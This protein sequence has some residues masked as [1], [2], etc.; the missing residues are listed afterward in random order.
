MDVTE[1]DPKPVVCPVC[2]AKSPPK[3]LFCSSCGAY[4]KGGEEDAW[5]DLP[6]RQPP[7]KQPGAS[8]AGA[9]PSAPGRLA[10]DMMDLRWD[11]ADP[12]LDPHT[13]EAPRNRRRAVSEP[14]SERRPPRKRH[15]WVLAFFLAVILV[16]AVGLTAAVA[17]RALFAP[18]DNPAA[19][20]GSVTT[21]TTGTDQGGSTTTQTT[22]PSQTTTSTSATQPGSL[23]TAT[24][25]TA[26]STL[27]PE[28]ENSYGASNVSDG[29][30]STCWSEGVGGQGVGETIRVDLDEAATL[31][32]IEIANGYQKDQRRF[33]GNPR[34]A[35]LR[36]EYST[37]E[38]QTVQLYDSMGYQI[39]TPT[40]GAVEWVTFE[41]RSTYPGDSWDD[42]SISEIRLYKAQ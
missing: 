3:R 5:V 23:L 39:V 30:L 13:T 32:K 42:T 33:E 35:T 40:A 11:D 22:S 34:V 18:N 15:H 10:P 20:G 27:A 12:T 2:G 4:L 17:Y 31:S 14:P 9:A 25:W 26:S 21:R 8:Q 38:T 29:D 1:Q 16:G 19:D 28:G 41:I 24:S 37:G 36:I 6:P 7:L